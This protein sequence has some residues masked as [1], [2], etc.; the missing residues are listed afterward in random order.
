MGKS[1]PK[2]NK[3]VFGDMEFDE[4]KGRFECPPTTLNN[5]KVLPKKGREMP[6]GEISIKLGYCR[7]EKDE[8]GKI[9]K[10]EYLKED[11]QVKNEEVR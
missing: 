10:V 3:I 1:I 7:Y 5:K 4:E 8:N 6:E 2:E 11:K 9:T